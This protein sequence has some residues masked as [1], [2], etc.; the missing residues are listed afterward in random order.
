[1]TRQEINILTF[2]CVGTFVLSIAILCVALCSSAHAQLQPSKI[3]MK[4]IMMIESGGCA[5][6]VGRSGEIGLYQISPVVL[7]EYNERHNSNY[8]RHHLFIPKINTKIALWYLDKRIPQM[9][10]YFKKPVTIE[11]IIISYNAGIA[12]VAH[13]RE[14][15]KITKRYL[16][17]YNE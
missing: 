14:I 13:D 6:R 3:D 1:M 17:K 16:E 11:N 7:L 12:Y 4:K 10:R 15:P 8:G 2:Y 9:L 5:I